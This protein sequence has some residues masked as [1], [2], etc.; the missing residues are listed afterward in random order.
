M[1]NKH[2][3]D[4]RT[5]K[6]TIVGVLVLV[7]IVIVAILSII[8]L[9]QSALKMLEKLS[10]LDAVVI[11]ALITGSISI[12]VTV[13]SKVI[14]YNNTRLE[15]LAKKREKPYEAFIAMV[16]RVQ[17]NTKKPNSYTNEEMLIDVKAF[18]EELTL[19]GSKNVAEK[20]VRFRLNGVKADSS[21]NILVIL[22][23]IMNEMR[24]DMGVK[25]VKKGTLLSFFVNDLADPKS[26]KNKQL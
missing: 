22:E 8:I 10:K 16:Y 2:K 5:I 18:S 9:G 4:K 21:E 17:E 15:Y 1:E 11:V 7:I 23:D 12:V 3:N 24:A 6:N 26:L 25:K 14:D 20:W 19:W 13:I